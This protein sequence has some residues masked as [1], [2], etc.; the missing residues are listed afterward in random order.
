RAKF[1]FDGG[2]D[3]G[4]EAQFSPISISK[5]VHSGGHGTLSAAACLGMQHLPFAA[6]VA[7]YVVGVGQGPKPSIKLAITAY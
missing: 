6:G 5:P 2:K 3:G 7:D 1:G 4:H